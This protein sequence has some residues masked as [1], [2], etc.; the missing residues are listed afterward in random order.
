M[1]IAVISDIHGNYDALAAVLEDIDHSNVDTIVCLGDC[2]GYGA[3]PEL[4]VRTLHER[5]IFS[6]LGNHEQAVLDRERLA[7]FNPMAKA[8]LLKT[9]SMLSEDTLG[10][11]KTFP[12][13]FVSHGCRFVHGFPPD[14]VTTYSF[15][16]SPEDKRQIL[17]KLTEYVCFFGHTHDLSITSFDGHTLTESPLDSKN[18]PILP[19]HRYVIN[20]GSVGQPRDGNNNAKYVIWDKD[21]SMLAVKYVA[22][23]IAAAAEKIIAAGLPEIHAR[24]LW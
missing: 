5:K 12:T 16:L 21:L 11:I 22:Y 7:W 2:I 10:I 1:K 18:V 13:S 4:V 20:V 14:S 19:D 6:T 15:E 9:A 8:S 23:D 3:E 17:D 24:R